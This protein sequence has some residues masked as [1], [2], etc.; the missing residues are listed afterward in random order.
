MCIYLLCCNAKT[1]QGS[2][3]QMVER[4]SVARTD[5]RLLDFRL[6]LDAYQNAIPTIGHL[7]ICSFAKS[8]GILRG[9]IIDFN[10]ISALS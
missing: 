8:P 2:A 6:P 1:R 10:P 7:Y 5:K 4:N 3:G 9:R